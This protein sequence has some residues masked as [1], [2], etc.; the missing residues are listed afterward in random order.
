MTKAKGAK[1]ATSTPGSEDAPV[2]VDPKFRKTEKTEAVE[3]VAPEVVEEAAEAA[4]RYT[5]EKGRLCNQYVIKSANG[6]V[7][8]LLRGAYTRISKAEAAIEKYLKE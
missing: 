5:I 6:P 1:T 8:K 7:P 4:T 2:K 3:E